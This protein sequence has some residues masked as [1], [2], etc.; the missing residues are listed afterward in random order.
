[1]REIISYKLR[2]VTVAIGRDKNNG[3]R[4][5][6][7]SMREIV[8]KIHHK[9]IGKIIEKTLPLAR[10]LGIGRS[11]GIGLEEID[12]E[13]HYKAKKADHHSRDIK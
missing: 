12:I 3:I 8:F 1:M 10:H 5:A 4:K 7:E 13:E 2:S 9:I 11:M 6:R